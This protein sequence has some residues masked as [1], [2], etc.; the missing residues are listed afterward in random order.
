MLF[1]FHKKRYYVHGDQGKEDQGQELNRLNRYV[2]LPGGLGHAEEVTEVTYEVQQTALRLDPLVVQHVV[3]VLSVYYVVQNCLVDILEHQE[4]SVAAHLRQ[5]LQLKTDHVTQQDELANLHND[6]HYSMVESLQGSLDIIDDL[7]VA[8]VETVE[9]FQVVVAGNQNLSGLFVALLLDLLDQGVQ[10]GHDQDSQQVI[11]T[12]QTTDTDT[13]IEHAECLDRKD[14]S[15]RAILIKC[16]RI[17]QKHTLFVVCELDYFKQNPTHE[18]VAVAITSRWHR[19]VIIVVQL[20][21]ANLLRNERCLFHVDV[22]ANQ[23]LVLF[24]EYFQPVAPNKVL[25]VLQTRLQP[26]DSAAKVLQP[27]LKILEIVQW[28][29]KLLVQYLSNQLNEL[30]LDACLQNLLWV[31]LDDSHQITLHVENTLSKD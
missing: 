22:A 19:Y 26:V 14:L 27:L 31:D 13:L 2:Y 6:W 21:V 11:Q 15:S 3:S 28:E 10:M 25:D 16:I 4:E 17:A 20:L 7:L 9:V 24:V 30:F 18:V 8:L 12:L 23:P 5:H 29:H 1:I